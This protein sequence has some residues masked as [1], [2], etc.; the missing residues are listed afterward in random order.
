LDAQVALQALV[1]AWKLPAA[2][3]VGVV[4]LQDAAFQ[5]LAA[6]AGFLKQM[7]LVQAKRE[8][9]TATSEGRLE[10]VRAGLLPSSNVADA[11]E[12]FV[13]M[14]KE[15]EEDLGFQKYLS[16]VTDF[17]KLYGWYTREGLGKAR[18]TLKAGQWAEMETSPRLLKVE[19]GAAAADLLLY[20]S[21]LD[22]APELGEH[23][24]HTSEAYVEEDV[25]PTKKV[26][27]AKPSTRIKKL[28][29]PAESRKKTESVKVAKVEAAIDPRPRRT[30]AK[31][32][33][34]TSSPASSARK[35]SGRDGGRTNGRTKPVKIPSN[36][37]TLVKSDA[38]GG[39]Y[40]AD[41]TSP[42]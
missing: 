39:Y 42:S 27:R 22:L 5:G 25:A 37:T 13:M 19:A 32:M 17:D 18:S 8:S 21:L 40:G 16:N 41:G 34:S 38:G 12:T 35:G 7:Y 4:D 36:T 31:K 29:R 6:K 9:T 23:K 26:K 11:L 24:G 15:G 2:S 30:E 1:N 20:Q 14:Q 28:A 33:A 3:I 10:F